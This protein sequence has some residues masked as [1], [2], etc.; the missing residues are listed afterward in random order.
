MDDYPLFKMRGSQS[1]CLTE[2]DWKIFIVTIIFSDSK[3]IVNNSLYTSVYYCFII[4]LKN[5][6]LLE[7]IFGKENNFHV[8]ESL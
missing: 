4:T 1:R 8:K 7:I 2:F 6:K 5:K 3:Y